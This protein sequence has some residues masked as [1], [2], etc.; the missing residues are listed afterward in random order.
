MIA[1]TEIKKKINEVFIRLRSEATKSFILRVVEKHV[2]V[3]LSVC[4]C[5][6]VPA[7]SL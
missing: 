6:C 3:C 1:G 4:V 5:L 2:S 7:V